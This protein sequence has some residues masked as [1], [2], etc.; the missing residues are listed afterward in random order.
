MCVLIYYHIILFILHPAPPYLPILKPY[1]VTELCIAAKF[2]KRGE[3]QKNKNNERKNK[4]TAKTND[5][6]NTFYPS[7]LKHKI[8]DSLWIAL[9]VRTTTTLQTILYDNFRKYNIIFLIQ[10]QMHPPSPS[11]LASLLDSSPLP[12]S[13][14]FQFCVEIPTSSPHKLSDPATQIHSSISVRA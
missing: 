2:T 10:Y 1:H 13:V 14:F 5:A 8:A 9:S 7:F 3:I 12:V 4:Q 6:N 11:S